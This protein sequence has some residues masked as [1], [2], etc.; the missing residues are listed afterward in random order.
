MGSL[1]NKFFHEN[2]NTHTDFTDFHRESISF[3]EE[4]NIFDDLYYM[5]KS[6]SSVSSVRTKSVFSVSSV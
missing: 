6:V 2:G 3:L 1:W 5:K 4:R